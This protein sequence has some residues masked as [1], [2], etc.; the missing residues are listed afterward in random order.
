MAAGLNRKTPSLCS[1]IHALQKE[2]ALARVVAVV[3]STWRP[4]SCSPPPLL[5]LLA[6]TSFGNHFL[7]ERLLELCYSGI[8]SLD[9]RQRSCRLASRLCIMTA[10]YIVHRLCYISDYLVGRANHFG[11]VSQICEL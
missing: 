6:I 5:S 1:I 2:R 8:V 4:K 9:I 7:C 3:K 11:F 10:D